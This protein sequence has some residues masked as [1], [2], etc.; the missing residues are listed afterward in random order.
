[1]GDILFMKT[2]RTRFFVCLIGSLLTKQEAEALPLVT[3]QDNESSVSVTGQG[4]TSFQTG[5]IDGLPTAVWWYGTLNPLTG[6]F[7]L[8][9]RSGIWVDPSTS[10]VSDKFLVVA[11]LGVAYGVF[12]SE[13]FPVPASFHIPNTT[14][15]IDLASFSEKDSETGR[16]TELSPNPDLLSVQAVTAPDVQATA[17]LLVLGLSALRAYSAARRLRRLIPRHGRAS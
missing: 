4:F 5:T 10:H 11:A 12:L 1:M 16:P 17:L 2:A 14:I 3:I 15:R 13:P 8:G 6:S 9:T 7:G